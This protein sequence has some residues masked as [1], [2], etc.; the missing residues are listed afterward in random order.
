[1]FRR[2]AIFIGSAVAGGLIYMALPDGSPP[3]NTRF[4]VADIQV[5]LIV[6][7][8]LRWDVSDY[9]RWKPDSSKV[10]FDR[11]GNI[12][13][14]SEQIAVLDSLG[15]TIITEQGISEYLQT[16]GWEGGL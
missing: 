2:V 15:A 12:P 11:N 3:E 8:Q 9:P 10:L 16:N 4:A 1:M 14:T 6:H 13:F 7:D 5:W